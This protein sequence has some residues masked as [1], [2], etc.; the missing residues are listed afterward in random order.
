[1]LEAAGLRGAC[2]YLA[3]FDPVLTSA[4]AWR[5]NWQ[6]TKPWCKPFADIAAAGGG[7]PITYFEM[8]TVAAFILFAHVPAD[9]V[10]LEVG[11]GGRLDATNVITPAVSVITRISYDHTYLLGDT[12]EKIAAEKAGIMKPGVPCVMGYQAD[13]VVKATLRARAAEVGC[14][15]IEYGRDFW[16]EELEDGFIYKA[17]QQTGR[18]ADQRFP[19]PALLGAHQILNACRRYY[20]NKDFSCSA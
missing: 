6:M 11:L 5:A 2:V 12:L 10:L 1:M 8:T 17:D 18:P 3:A 15:L 19:L 9:V 13:E 16:T 14:E 4:S 20:R 7:A